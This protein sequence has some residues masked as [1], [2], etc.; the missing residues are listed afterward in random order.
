MQEGTTPLILAAANGHLNCVQEL[1]EQGADP[2]G[3]RVV[4]VRCA[5]SFVNIM[6]QQLF[7]ILFLW[8]EEFL[9]IVAGRASASSMYGIVDFTMTLKQYV[10]CVVK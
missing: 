9:T 4:S 7:E 5:T 1:L 2:A 6:I 8:G 3:K 10:A